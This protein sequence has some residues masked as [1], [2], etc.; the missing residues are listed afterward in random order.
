V[1]RGPGGATLDGLIGG[2][3]G[4]ILL[5][6]DG[7]DVA[8]LAVQ[9]GGVVPADPLDGGEFDLGGGLPNAV[10]DQLGL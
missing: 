4:R 7:W 2:L 5:E 6:L 9:A 8:E 3:D 10:S 1:E